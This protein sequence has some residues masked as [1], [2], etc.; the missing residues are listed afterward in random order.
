[1]TTAGSWRHR[2]ALLSLVA[3]LATTLVMTDAA[4]V[5]ARDPL[6]TPITNPDLAP[7]CGLDVLLILDESR[8][9]DDAG[10]GQNVR[11]AVKAFTS[12]MNN[13]GS[14][15]STTEFSGF[16][17][18]PSIGG[19]PEGAYIPITDATKPDL[20]AY[21][22]TG[23]DPRFAENW[24]DAFRS[25]NPNF[26]VRP[27]AST[28]HLTLFL[29]AGEPTRRI[30]D[31]GPQARHVT[32]FEYL[33]KMEL[34]RNE[35]RR[36][37]NE[38]ATDHAVTTAN[39]IKAQGSHILAVTVGPELSSV[40]SLDRLSL[41]TGSD[42]YNGAGTFD[43]AT[44]DI[45]EVPDPAT[46]TTALT[47]IAAQL[48][49]ASISVEKSTGPSP[50][51]PWE[52]ADTPTGPYVA[53]GDTV[54][55]SYE[56]E[57]TGD[58]IL[59]G[60]FVT[61]SDPGV[62]VSCPGSPLAPGE[63]MTC[64]ASGTATPGQYTNTGHVSG[65]PPSGI[66]VTDDDVSHYFGA[67]PAVDIEKLTNGQDSDTAPG[68]TLLAFGPPVTW[69]YEVTNTG[70]IDLPT[71]VV[72]DDQGLTP[73]YVSGD[74][75]D[76]VLNPGETWTYEATGPA[77]VGQYTNLGSVTASPP[78]NPPGFPALPDASDDDPSNYWGANPLIIL[79]KLVNGVS[80]SAAPGPYILVG[81]PV[82]WT[83]LVT[84]N[85]NLD[86]NDVSV[87]DSDPAVDPVYDSG[88]DG[89][90]LLNVGE[91]WTFIATG[92][93]TVG[94]YQNTGTANATEPSTG[95]VIT[96]FDDEFYFGA[97]TDVDIEK[98]TNGEDVIAPPG[99]YILAGD[100]VT[101]TYDITNNSNVP[102]SNISV[103]DDQAVTV[104]CPSTTL[105]VDGTMT[106]EAAGP[107]TAGQ[108]TNIGSVT[109][110][111]PANPPGIAPLPDVE[112]DDTSNYFGV[113]PA[114][115]IEKATNGQDADTAPGPY[116]VYP[117]PPGS[118]TWTYEVSNTGNVD[119]TNVVVTDDQGVTPSYVSGDDTDLDVLNVGETWVYEATGD[120][121]LGQYTNEGT[122]TAASPTG[123]DVTDADLSHY[124]G[125]TA[126]IDI[127]KYTNGEQADVPSAALDILVGDPITWT[128]EVTNPGNQD[129]TD[130]TV[131]DDQ[132]VTPAYVSGDDGDG[133][134][135][136]G[137]T[138]VYEATGT[139]T[140]GAY[141]NQ[142]QV[143]ATDVTGNIVGDIDASN[144][145]GVDPSLEIDKA[146]NNASVDSAPGPYIP[147]GD[148]ITWTY[149]VTN[150]GN[151]DLA[152]ITVDD[153]DP[154]VTPLYVSGDD[155]DG[156][157]NPGETWI[158]EANGTA[159]AGQYQNTASATGIE[160]NLE[161]GLASTD[162][163]WY[164]GVETAI[165]IEKFT[166][167]ADVSAPPGPYIPVG[168]PVTWTYEITNNSNVPLHDIGIVDDQGVIVACP[169]TT[170]EPGDT[171]SCE[172]EGTAI[173]GQYT[174]VGTVTA[175]P[176]ENVPGFAP[177][178][179]VSDFDV[180]RYFGS[181]PGIE[182]AKSTNGED[183]DTA[184]GPYVSVGA[185][186][187]WAYEV[188][189][190]GNV[191]LSAVSVSDDQ[192]LTPTFASGDD[193]DGIL[194][195][196]ETWVFEATG[197][198][199]FGQYANIGSA[200][201][202]PPVGPDVTDEDPSHYFGTDSSIAIDK[203]PDS[204]YIQSGS[205][206]T[207]TITVTNT[208]NAVLVDVAVADPLVPACDAAVG[209]LQPGE[210]VSYECTV[211]SVTTVIN[212]VAEVTGSDPG[213]GVV[214]ASDEA[215]VGPWNI[216]GTGTIGDTVFYDENENGVQDADEA[217]VAGAVVTIT[218]LDGSNMQASYT[219][220][221]SGRYTAVGLVDGN[222]L[223]ELD[224]SS[225]EG[226]LTTASSY[227][228][229]LAVGEVRSDA[230]FGIHDAL[231]ATGADTDRIGFA[232]LMALLFGLLLV[233]SARR[234][235]PRAES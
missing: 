153:S 58:L 18:R 67:E 84:N 121:I 139:A 59:S 174:N 140:A 229:A 70:N 128:Y 165:D 35:N 16:A 138:W 43:V 171:M 75:G 118:V 46:L 4:P 194:N 207:F 83:Y 60:I 170:L 224:L 132:G 76:N 185:S 191:D 29:V 66:R 134:L 38:V 225:V 125:L 158:Y 34:D 74:D 80:V 216:A 145:Y 112:D 26:S 61:D 235:E 183:A 101:W 89:D 160:P 109:A 30:R 234:R 50:T 220:D 161:L 223:V 149:E 65:A 25:G 15:I 53:V 151:V 150:T 6:E 97:I 172:A 163:E 90:G 156:I 212:N 159:V 187:N 28:P 87:T 230:N 1:M 180:S 219:T 64:S 152:T 206:H 54:Y 79:D 37:T 201:A 133:L 68:E 124:F 45:Y 42:V 9:V 179:D 232:G 39:G 208:S 116:L 73:T 143:N 81:E 114:I 209:S 177:L 175:S 27:S 62:T 48:C 162:D 126:L 106:C 146:T 178:P 131:T 99:P 169:L 77:T 100:S 203:S 130:I 221:A 88:D 168:D 107:A 190:T 204:A 166:N 8:S 136:P 127:E 20:D 55:W 2:T 11:D 122:V 51:G 181:D 108:Y 96:S 196:G 202:A 103:T 200:T 91:T 72:T 82:T 3:L 218:Y 69:T 104:T 147:V 36:A 214:T 23:Y 193:G 113:D 197:T 205:P 40:A 154:T 92:I 228:I 144:Y 31:D 227:T 32:D 233:I 105:D 49:T 188:T 186:V 47:E 85:G 56:V 213:G 86:I 33:N 123:L 12:A 111:P 95:F 78:A 182:I 71:V 141:A 98:Y 63:S 24:E 231:P 110:S 222:Y 217:G 17:R 52:D 192:G 102:L 117:S 199:G 14:T 189:N 215:F 120:V 137:E 195:P 167:G 157:L 13:T 94:Q 226:E 93:A 184:P 7:A 19:A 115:D 173:A 211:N 44:H 129:L 148:P 119:L 164:F 142:G 176:P 5:A 22:D 210:V 57:N 135:N 155:G 10:A 198:A 21:M 41:V